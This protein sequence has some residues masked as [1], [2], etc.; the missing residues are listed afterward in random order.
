LTPVQ[1]RT[2]SPAVAIATGAAHACAIVLDPGS[3]AI[4]QCWG[5]S[6]QGQLGA[7][8]TVLGS[9]T[10]MNVGGLSGAIDIAAGSAHTCALLVNS[11]MRCWGGNTFGQVGNGSSGSSFVTPASVVV[12]SGLHPLFGAVAVSAGDRHSCAILSDG[13][14]R[15]WGDDT[16]GQLGDSM[17]NTQRAIANT[18][19]LG[20][21]DAF[22]IVTGGNHTC[23]V[24]V[25][26]FTGRCWGDNSLGQLGNGTTNP[27]SVPNTVNGVPGSTGIGGRSIRASDRWSCARRG[28]ASLACWGGAG[29]NP[30]GP[31]P[32]TV[33][34]VGSGFTFV[35]GL[36]KTCDLQS[37]G[38]ANCFLNDNLNGANGY[39]PGV[40]G[41][42]QGNQ[43]ACE[44]LV[45]G[46]VSCFG[47]NSR[48]QLGNS[49]AGGS[50]QT[51]VTVLDTNGVI[52][53]GIVMISSGAFHTCAVRV[54]GKVF[55]WGDNTSGQLG[56]G[57]VG[58]F[59][60]FA[61]PVVG[62]SNIVA[63]SGSLDTESSGFGNN[64]FTCALSAV[65]GASC[66][67]Y[68][69]N[70]QLGNGSNPQTQPVAETVSGLTNAAAL[71]AGG[72]HACAVL[73]DGS[74]MCW[75]D[76]SRD[77]LG[78][79]DTANHNAPVPVIQN[80]SVINGLTF[81]F[82]LTWVTAITA[83]KSHTCS[84]QAFGL[85]RCWGDNSVGE[86]GN[87][88]ITSSAQPRPTAVNSFTA[89]VDPAASLR[90]NS[91]IAVVTVLINCPAGNAHIT[92][93][94]QQG[95]STGTGQGVSSCEG[96]LVRVPITVPAQG[97][98]GFQSGAAIAKVEALVKDDGSIIEDQHW[99]RA[100][101]LS[102]QQ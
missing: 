71:S 25:V 38:I 15:C 45:N 34:V 4:V 78:A 95:S 101:V 46:T 96:G 7:G 93:T 73:A 8:S 84:L 26:N 44:L 55:C 56:L 64:S 49:N 5:L 77:Q 50:S 99:T 60:G 53:Q 90:T 79:A 30:V 68:G 33:F 19:V 9:L 89:N 3:G 69:L 48:G 80:I 39:G 87:G 54:D 94:L 86:V 18:A 20:L 42:A 41:F 12:D 82:R 27:A 83:G 31:N 91:R 52:L 97:P 2:K 17:N 24:E 37:D 66:W 21:N 36:S 28:N 16:H 47:S 32:L 58:G 23:A 10:P 72:S 59:S 61:S 29:S 51:F 102:I 74:A 92:L 63:V 85:P 75:G 98:V 40:V 22:E 81:A 70:G 14:V 1:A 67:G 11:S 88:T 43:H 35:T 76:D 57:T 62:L 100:V 6:T 65:G 13:S